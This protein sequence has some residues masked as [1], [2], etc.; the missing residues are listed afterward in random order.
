MQ[1]RSLISSNQLAL[2]MAG[3]SLM[4]PYTFL[5]VIRT[6]PANQ[7][8][9]I[10]QLLTMVFILIMNLPLLYIINKF[11]GFD[12][13]ETNEIIL[14]RVGGTIS[15]VM[16]LLLSI[17]CFVGCMLISALFVESYLLA[18]TP[19]WIIFLFIIVPGAFAAIKGAGTVCRL[20]FFTVPLMLATIVLFFVVGVPDMD[21]SL[22]QPVLKDSKFLDIILG[23]FYTAARYSEIV[24]LFGFGYYLK[25]ECKINSTYF[26][27]F[28]IF[29]IFFFIVTISTL[30]MLGSDL[31]KISNNPFLAFTRQVGG[32][33]FFQRVHLLNI[34]AWFIGIVVKLMAYNYTASYILSRIFRAKTHKYFV[35]PLS[36]FGFIVGMLPFMKRMST[37]HILKSDKIFP[38]VSV[39]VAVG[40]PIILCIVYFIRKKQIDKIISVRKKTKDKELQNFYKE[41][42]S[43]AP[44]NEKSC[45]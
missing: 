7:D 3:S 5:S 21:I 43:I 35:Y 30:L 15:A 45:S 12:L 22:I 2:V 6:P 8:V 20:A 14:G 34:M 40:V 9:W 24:L 38:F 28:A 37:I 44:I 42:A 31:A 11:R 29:G 27:S 4:F 33:E 23:A 13:V 39:S 18:E 36:L 17:F 32:Q 41:K 16:F 25:V 26:K 10:V 19:L 1:N